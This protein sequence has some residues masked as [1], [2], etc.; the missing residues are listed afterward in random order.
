MAWERLPSNRPSLDCLS[1]LW[2]QVD[3]F[4]CRFFSSDLLH[5][6][7]PHH[8]S[9]LNQAGSLEGWWEPEVLFTYPLPDEDP[10]ALDPTRGPPPAQL[11]DLQHFCCPVG[12]PTQR[13]PVRDM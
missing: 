4:L 1:S 6:G 2:W 9:L 7:L 5:L 11:S 12:V 10:D 8:P 3:T 13:V